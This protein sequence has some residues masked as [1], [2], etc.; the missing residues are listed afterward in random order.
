MR[1]L[2]VFLVLV[3]LLSGFGQVR[4][5]IAVD[6]ALFTPLSP[7]QSE[8]CTLRLSFQIG[9]TYYWKNGVIKGVAPD[10]T[11]PMGT[12]PEIKKGKTFLIIRYITSEAGAKLEYWKKGSAQNKSKQDQVRISTKQ[13]NVIDLWIGN[14]MAKV[15]GVPVA[16]D[17]TDSTGQVAPYIKG[18]GYTMLPLRF[19]GNNLGA[20]INWI[21]ASMTAELIFIDEDCQKRCCDFSIQPA[22]E[23]SLCPGQ[24]KSVSLIV[25]NLCQAKKLGLSFSPG[26][27]IQ[28]LDTNQISVEPKESALL[29][30]TLAMPVVMSDKAV[31]ILK[32]TTDC[33]VERDVP[34]VAIFRDQQCQNDCQWLCGCIGKLTVSGESLIVEFFEG[35]AKKNQSNFID[36]GSSKDLIL[37]LT[38]A[39]YSDKYGSMTCVQICVDDD[40]DIQAWKAMPDR[41]P[42]CQDHVFAT[43]DSVDCNLKIATGIDP[44]GTRWVFDLSEFDGC[45]VFGVGKSY[46]FSGTTVR[47]KGIAFSSSG[48]LEVSSIQAKD[49]QGA[50]LEGKLAIVQCTSNPAMAIVDTADGKSVEVQLLFQ[51]MRNPDGR[52]IDCR[53]ARE[54]ECIRLVGYFQGEV[55]IA[56]KG[57]ILPCDS[58]FE[59]LECKV[60]SVVQE[61][62]ALLTVNTVVGCTDEKRTFSSPKML[63]DDMQGFKN[64]LSYSISGNYA[65][66]LVSDNRIIRWKPLLT[67]CGKCQEE[68]LF[69]IVYASKAENSGKIVVVARNLD[70]RLVTFESNRLDKTNAL[71]IVSYKGVAKISFDQTQK[72]SGFRTI[73]G[74]C[75]LAG[76]GRI[77]PSKKSLSFSSVATEVQKGNVSTLS[78]EL[79]DVELQQL[80]A[81]LQTP[82]NPWES[83]AQYGAGWIGPDQGT[84]GDSVVFEQSFCV[85][86]CT[87]SRLK[88]LCT[89][90]TQVFFDD[91]KTPIGVVDGISHVSE[92]FIS[93][94]ATG[95]HTL[96]FVQDKSAFQG[97]IFV[98]LGQKSDNCKPSSFQVSFGTDKTLAPVCE[99]G[100][101]KYALTVSNTSDTSRKFS[102]TPVSVGLLINPSTITIAPD[103]EE[104]VQLTILMPENKDKLD[105]AEFTFLIQADEFAPQAIDFSIPYG[106][107]DSCSLSTDNTLIILPAMCKDD[108]TKIEVKLTNSCLKELVLS[109][110][111]NDK[112]LE[113]PIQ[114]LKIDANG[115]ASMVVSF[116]MPARNSSR[117]LFTGF[118][119]ESEGKTIISYDIVAIFKNEAECCCDFEVVLQTNFVAEQ[120]MEP[121]ET[122]TYDY[123]VK[124][125]CQGRNLNF[126][127]SRGE[128]II[129]TS[130]EKF[131]LSDS[132]TMPLQ[133]KVM[134]PEKKAE[135]A[136]FSFAVACDC[137]KVANI[138]FMVRYKPQELCCDYEVGLMQN[139]PQPFMLEPGTEYVLGVGIKNKCRS[140]TLSA[141]I[142]IGDNILAV[143]PQRLVI[144]PG[145]I[146]GF[147]LLLK[148]PQ[149]T[150]GQTF[151]FTFTV[152][153]D[154]CDS[155]TYEIPAACGSQMGNCCE[156]DITDTGHELENLKL[157][158]GQTRS[159]KLTLTNKCKDRT[160]S[161]TLAGGANVKVEPPSFTIEAGKSIYITITITMPLEAAIGSQ[162]SFA[163]MVTVPGCTNRKYTIN[164]SCVSC[165]EDPNE[166]CDFTLSM[167]SKLPS[168]VV[169]GSTFELMFE[170]CNN[171]QKE[172]V[173]NITGQNISGGTIAIGANTCVRFR[174]MF[175]VP[176]NATGAFQVKM[177]ALLTSPSGCIGKGKM[178]EASVQI[179][180]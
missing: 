34:I 161:G 152:T 68:Q 63:G 69:E 162:L 94:I 5:A 93:N 85:Q 57:D 9:K 131:T 77:V 7:S 123:L 145:Q 27:G 149:C 105:Q 171:C 97:L 49:G 62:N 108:S 10:T 39:Q 174:I 136:K 58:S 28:S 15:N 173:I 3:Q 150:Q 167:I 79:D 73:S 112:L 47:P 129:S 67:G 138:G 158:P 50:V 29:K 130:P 12:A 37:G 135:Y 137:G 168:C 40:G 18:S 14:P 89:A 116:K 21:S 144:G 114:D 23:I 4:N 115:S 56:C 38:F 70:G 87:D 125:K 170:L 74:V 141:S 71:S 32:V 66:L 128:N 52:I 160:L 166:C 91:G 81:N 113:L 60:E 13:G 42:C 96:K 147:K 82:F 169:P 124:N 16:I 64:L 86:T 127:V 19:I 75:C 172:M 122:F 46:D 88:I 111:T 132:K 179:C 24:E 84:Q 148:M 33:G 61:T 175:T 55:F 44:E 142:S 95:K 119:L 45:D 78:K 165:G 90:K 178:F 107:C 65:R 6:N 110:K 36:T 103:T 134:M 180:N 176:K 118:N 159:I 140:V 76:Q 120:T 25:K 20:T 59:T 51:S 1:K 48:L 151:V 109:A 83:F 117:F 54:G 156:Y 139:L 72:M 53:Q 11:P 101:R 99:L 31:F 92:V 106:Q 157:C 2:L 26:T 121:G 30:V 164:A 100:K 41:N 143:D 153:V 98:L 154:G 102:I 126:A 104:L 177:T 8:D 22:E 80:K 155:K 163:F 133:V 146:A 17:P 35:C 43:L